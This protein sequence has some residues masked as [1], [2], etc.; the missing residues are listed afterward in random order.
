MHSEKII[1]KFR[2]P[3]ILI[4]PLLTLLFVFGLTRLQIE[5]DIN[6]LIPADMPSRVQTDRIEK[7]FGSNKLIVIVLESDDVLDPSTL[8]RVRDL[9]R[10]FE[11]RPEFNRVTSL[12]TLK[13]IRNEKGMMVVDPAVPTR[14]SDV[15]GE[16]DILRKKLLNNPFV[17]GKVLSEDLKKTAI[18][19]TVRPGNEENGLMQTIANILEEIPGKERIHMGGLPVVNALIIEDISRDVVYLLPIG[20]LLM[21]LML[22]FAFRELRG[23]VL[24]LFC[25]LMAIVI[26]FGLMPLLDW[27]ISI[28]TILMPVILIAVAN[29][30]GIHLIAKYQEL[31]DQ[32]PDRSNK[33]LALGA[34]KYLKRPIL[35]T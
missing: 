30:Y 29:D 8:Q 31:R 11:R 1:R 20:F 22:Y 3:I 9:T 23:V 27:R 32:H 35:V 7:V 5:G 6:D 33:Q 28:V 17:K 4:F 14:L 26:S 13:H 15:S 2:L 24:P 19:L 21:T 10:A 25:V 34:F 18:L 12:Y 16:R